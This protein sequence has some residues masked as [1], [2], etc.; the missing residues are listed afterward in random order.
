MTKTDITKHASIDIG[1][2]LI[3]TN[4][5]DTDAAIAKLRS[6]LWTLMPSFDENS[7]IAAP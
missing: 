4:K 5:T 6:K 3:P 1:I 7:D 2:S